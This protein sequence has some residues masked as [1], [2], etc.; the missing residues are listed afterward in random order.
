MYLFTRINTMAGARLRDG[1][2][3]SGEI[4]EFVNETSE[5]DVSLHSFVFGRPPGTVAWSCVVEDHATMLQASAA[6][7]GDDNYL[8]RTTKAADLFEGH[9]QDDFREVVHVA[10]QMDGPGRYTSSVLASCQSDRMADVMAWGVEMADLVHGVS[11]RPCAFLADAYGD[12]SG[13]AWITSFDDPTSLDSLRSGLRENADY[14][15]HLARSGGLFIPGTG[16]TSLLQLV[17]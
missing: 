5:L 4:T 14:L 1:I 6:L 15:G 13:V 10:G 2:R 8:D 3:F 7:E 12:F 9:P 11:G 17:R 16:R